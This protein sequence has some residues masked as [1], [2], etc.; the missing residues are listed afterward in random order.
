MMIL[1]GKRDNKFL[2][3]ERLYHKYKNRGKNLSTNN[4]SETKYKKIHRPLLEIFQKV[5]N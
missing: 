3:L 4:C 1:I 5:E 2:I